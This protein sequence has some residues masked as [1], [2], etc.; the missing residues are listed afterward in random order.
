MKDAL[1]SIQHASP[2]IDAPSGEQTSHIG[3][4][5]FM[6]VPF[7]K[8]RRRTLQSAGVKVDK[9]VLQWHEVSVGSACL[10]PS[11][12][13]RRM[14]ESMVIFVAK[15]FTFLNQWTSEA[16]CDGYVPREEGDLIE[17]HWAKRKPPSGLLFQACREFS[18]HV[19][20]DLSLMELPIVEV[21]VL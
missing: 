11:A 4:I 2:K 3:G 20:S 10:P 8:G 18:M 1:L 12:Y 14:R 16:F 9:E 5:F 17:P 19:R 13:A 6:C 21:S 7:Q 15:V